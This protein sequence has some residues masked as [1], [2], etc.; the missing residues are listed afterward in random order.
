M[1]RDRDD[2]HPDEHDRAGKKTRQS[3]WQGK[4]H[5]IPASSMPVRS[6]GIASH[7]RALLEYAE[8]PGG[9]PVYGKWNQMAIPGTKVAAAIGASDFPDS[10]PRVFWEELM[11]LREKEPFTAAQQERISFGVTNEEFVRKLYKHFMQLPA[12]G[13][14]TLHDKTVGALHPWLLHGCDGHARGRANHKALAGPISE[15]MIEI[16]CSSYTTIPVHYMCQIQ[17][18]LALHGM[19]WCDN[20]VYSGRGEGADKQLDEGF[21]GAPH[22]LRILRVFPSHVCWMLILEKLAY[23]MDCLYYKVP[24]APECCLSPTER[25][26]FEAPAV[27]VETLFDEKF[28]RSPLPRQ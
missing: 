14:V 12:E 1:K 5:V 10:N 13:G 11:G 7:V 6:V 9:A 16:K 27:R 26:L 15:Y 3:Q 21:M 22:R 28:E 8:G 2:R 23:F 25:A 19:P 18:G 20:V 4:L 17:V 24:P